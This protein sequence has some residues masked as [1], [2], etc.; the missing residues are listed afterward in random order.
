MDSGGGESGA[1][2][3]FIGVEGGE[4]R[5]RGGAHWSAVVELH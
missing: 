3:P 4:T 2:A 5:S 1:V